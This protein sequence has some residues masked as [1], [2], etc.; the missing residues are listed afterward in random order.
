VREHDSY[1]GLIQGA[2]REGWLLCRISDGSYGKKPFDIFG[3]SPTGQ[4]VAV[5]VKLMDSLPGR[6]PLHL[7][8]THQKAW[9]EAYA[10]RG[11]LSFLVV[12]EKSGHQARV[13]D[14][15]QVP[16]RRGSDG[17]TASF[18][19]SSH[20][21]ASGRTVYLGWHQATSQDSNST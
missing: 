15:G 14:L 13:F 7:L 5:E 16:G 2:Y 1:D 8:E 21:M 19:L 9:L 17:N 11:C 10:Q 3:C 18:D 6:P 12:V 20:R 4:A